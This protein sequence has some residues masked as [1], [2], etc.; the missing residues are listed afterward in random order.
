ME[1]EPAV[2]SRTNDPVL[3][4]PR[5]RR[6]EPETAT[7][8]LGSSGGYTVKSGDTLWGIS[9]KNKVSVKDLLTI[10]GMK[11]SSVLKIG[12]VLKIPVR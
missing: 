6:E 3:I 1:T 5:T 9:Q 2:S 11:E 4:S 12:K 8:S 7:R 10:N